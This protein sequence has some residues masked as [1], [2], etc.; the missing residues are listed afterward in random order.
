M[1]KALKSLFVLLLV[2]G[3]TISLTGCGEKDN[4]DIG[5]QDNNENKESNNN[6]SDEVKLYSDDTKLVFSVGGVYSAVFY[7]DGTNVTGMEYIY[8]YDDADT[9]KYSETV[10][11]ATYKQGEQGVKSITRS[12]RQIRI[13][14]DESTY[15]DLTVES[16]KAT[17]SMYEQIY[18][19]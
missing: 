17:Y 15:E 13:V 6:S 16:V 12:G 14:F 9:A 3:F 2:C 19:N 8:T 4:N 7:H 18:N 11:K 10:L 5:N 1:K